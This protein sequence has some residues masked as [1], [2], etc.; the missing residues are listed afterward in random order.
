MASSASRKR[1]RAARIPLLMIDRMSDARRGRLCRVLVELRQVVGDLEPGR[2]G[3]DEYVVCRT[4]GG[5][6]TNEPIATCTHAP[7]RTTEKRKDPHARHRV[8]LRSSSPKT[9]MLCNPSVIVSFSRSIPA[10][11]LKADPVAARHCE[12]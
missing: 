2:L 9:A 6:I 5:S 3:A 1:T 7:S 4:D 10:N 12:Q 11:A 8:S